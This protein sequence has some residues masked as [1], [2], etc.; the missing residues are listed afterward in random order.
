MGVSRNEKPLAR[1]FPGSL[2]GYLEFDSCN[3][4]FGPNASNQE[5][6]NSHR[7]ALSHQRLFMV[8]DGSQEFNED[9][10]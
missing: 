5:S 3:K 10:E 6:E 9:E 7:H 2:S 4:L 8:S 1:V